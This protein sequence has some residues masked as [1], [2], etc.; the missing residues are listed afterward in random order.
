MP[1]VNRTPAEQRLADDAGPEF[2]EALARGL[3][4]IQAF[5]RD[6]RMPITNRYR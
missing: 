3:R 6:R 4:I 5:G 1:R 2:L